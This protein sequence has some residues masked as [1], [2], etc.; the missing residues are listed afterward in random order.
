MLSVM[1]LFILAIGSAA[2]T[3]GVAAGVSGVAVTVA[4]G[5][6]STVTV[7]A[8]AGAAWGSGAGAAAGVGAGLTTT[9]WGSMGRHMRDSAAT[10]RRRG[11]AWTGVGRVMVVLLGGAFDDWWGVPPESSRREGPG[12]DWDRLGRDTCL[13]CWRVDRPHFRVR[14]ERQ[15]GLEKNR[16]AGQAGWWA[17]A[18]RILSTWVPWERMASWRTWLVTLNCLDQ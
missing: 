5:A 12:W 17:R 11:I 18:A 10:N 13:L 3:A 4:A 8:G 7:V 14:C 9:F 15:A 2:E 6:G 1:E 16:E